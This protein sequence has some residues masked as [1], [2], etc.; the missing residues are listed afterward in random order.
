MSIL[1]VYV[2]RLKLTDNLFI[3]AI[4]LRLYIQIGCIGAGLLRLYEN[5]F[6]FYKSSNGERICCRFF[7]VTW[8]YISVVLLLL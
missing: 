5:T 4:K 8:V 2:C 7:V 6:Y 3:D 1:F